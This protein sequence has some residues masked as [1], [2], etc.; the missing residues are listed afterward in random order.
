[1]N[2]GRECSAIGISSPSTF[3]SSHC[4]FS[5]NKVYRYRCITFY[6]TSGTIII[7]SAN[8]VHN[9]S[10]SGIGVVYFQGGGSRKMM[11][12]VFQNNDGCLFYVHSGSLE[13]CH[14]FIDHSSS[15]L[16]SLITV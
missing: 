12:C 8:I 7:A 3:T 9:N 6:S 4:T 2:N 16:S 1:M 11:Y 15:S 14:S 10:P 13:V 5:N